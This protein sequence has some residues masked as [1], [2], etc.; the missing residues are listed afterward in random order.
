MQRLLK[1][2]LTKRMVPET[3]KGVGHFTNPEKRAN[4]YCSTFEKRIHHAQMENRYAYM[5][6]PCGMN[7]LMNCR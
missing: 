6:G 2:Y 5:G 1:G 4:P 7:G 3:K